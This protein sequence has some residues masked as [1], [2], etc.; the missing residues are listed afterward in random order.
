MPIKKSAFKT[1]RQSK[2]RALKNA[3]IKSDLRALLRRS[4]QAIQAKKIEEAQDLVKKTLKALDKAAQKGVIKK[5]TAARKKSR[6]M[7]KFNASK[8]NLK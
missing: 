7:K 8:L 4:R 6:L 5:N 1:L 3:K 2:K